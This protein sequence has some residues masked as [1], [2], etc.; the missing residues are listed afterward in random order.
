MKAFVIKEYAH[1]S[2]LQLT[3]DAPEP[4]LTPGSDELLINVYSAGLNFFDVR[5]SSIPLSLC[6]PSH[7]GTQNR[8]YS[9]KENTR[10]SRRARS[11]SAPSLLVP[12]RSRHLGVRSSAAIG[13]L[14]IRRARMASKSLPSR[15]MCCR[16]QMRS[17]LTRVQVRRLVF[18]SVFLGC[19]TLCGAA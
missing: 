2:K 3:W 16:C 12:S 6:T 13:Y 15:S 5:L 17:R 1:P 14:D 9:R 19:G 11:Y 18:V 8:S 4:V 10:R 7:T